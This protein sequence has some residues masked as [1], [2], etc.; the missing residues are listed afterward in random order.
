MSCQSSYA[1]APAT[2]TC[3]SC[4]P[5]QNASHVIPSLRH[6]IPT[7]LGL[8]TPCPMPPTLRDRHLPSASSSGESLPKTSTPP[9]IPPSHL[10]HANSNHRRRPL[11]WIV[12]HSHPHQRSS[13]IVTAPSGLSSNLD[14]HCAAEPFQGARLGQ[15]TLNRPSLPSR[16][17]YY[18]Y[19]GEAYRAWASTSPQGVHS[20][21]HSDFGP[22]ITFL[23]SKIRSSPD[24]SYSL[25]TSLYTIHHE[26]P[27]DLAPFINEERYPTCP[28]ESVADLA[29]PM[30]SHLDL[31]VRPVGSSK[32][33]LSTIT[34]HTGRLP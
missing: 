16:S 13:S 11:S 29:T 18:T 21:A 5:N 7:A 33:H 19:P 31:R 10:N 3:F 2:S 17:R 32:S 26:S 8:D 4:S 12:G 23:P 6:R 9:H 20:R 22:C 24:S 28:P 1:S 14:D 25:D 27:T 30:P 15:S 34:H